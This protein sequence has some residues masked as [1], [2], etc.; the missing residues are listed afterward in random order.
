MSARRSAPRAAV[1]AATLLAALAPLAIPS[2]ASADFSAPALLSG[3]QALTLG[4]R[5]LQF[6]VPLQFEDAEGPAFAQEGGYVAFRGSLAGITGVYRR[7]LQSGEVALVAGEPPPGETEGFPSAP[8]ATAPSISADGRY[9]AFTSAATLVPVCGTS[10]AAEPAEAKSGCEPEADR[11]CPQVYV[12]DMGPPG[13]PTAPTTPDAYTLVSARNGSGEGLTYAPTCQGGSA[14]RLALAGAQ[15]AAG[16]ALSA[17]G[18]EVAFTILSSSNLDGSCSAPP[19][20]T[21]TTEASQVVVRDLVLKTTTLVSATPAGL[22]T[23][24]GGAYPS[25]ASEPEVSLTGSQPSASSAAISGDGSTVAWEGTNVPEQVPD[26]NDVSAGM[27]S[28][29]GPA[30]EVEPLWRRVADGPNAQTRRL[31]AGA[32]LEF[33]AFGI[34]NLGEAHPPVRGG[35][36]ALEPQAQDEFIAPVLSE[37]GHTVATIANAFTAA[38]EDSYA[39]VGAT[40]APPPEAYVVHVDDDPASPPQV[41]PLTATPDYAIARALFDGVGEIAISRDGSRV[42]FNTRRVSFALAPPNLTSPPAPETTYAYTYLVDLGTGIMQRVAN[43]YEG[44]PPDGEPGL[45]SLAGD[46]LSLTFAS[47]ASNLFYG[48]GTPGASQVYLTRETPPS[49]ELAPESVSPAPALSLPEPAWVLGATATPERDGSVLIDADVPGA[50]ALDVLAD[51]QLPATP[52]RKDSHV[53][54]RAQAS[55]RAKT[56]RT[57]AQAVRVVLVTRTVSRGAL[58]SANPGQLQVRL[59]AAS[60]YDGLVDGADGLYVVLHLSFRSPGHATLVQA[61]AVTLHDR[62]STRAKK[63]TAVRRGSGAHR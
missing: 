20:S 58:A 57:A 48:D 43:G 54:G 52:A 9:I 36:L 25:T 12:R 18:E 7:N 40:L 27:A 38:N 10:A 47:A 14:T 28:D 17:T 55:E 51:A 24:G 56:H 59:R 31:L 3:A 37:E 34:T 13:D 44:S 41:T 60:S 23:P 35:A 46:D 19:S 30:F 49:S 5:S 11:G 50:G 39:F 6:A 22:P 45:L 8:D 42:A 2:A 62:L 1:I 15:A 61:L 33:Y 29:G 63:R 53:G 4:T 32:G 21:C 26:A 16:A